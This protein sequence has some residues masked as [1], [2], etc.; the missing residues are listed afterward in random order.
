MG[1]KMESSVDE[2]RIQ[3]TID[4]ILENEYNFYALHT[5]LMEYKLDLNIVCKTHPLIKMARWH[6]LK[7]DMALCYLHYLI[8]AVLQNYMMYW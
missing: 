2:N 3:A 4:N 5:K 7:K 6:L 8:L 1:C